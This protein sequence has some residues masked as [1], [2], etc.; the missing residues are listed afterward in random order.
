MLSSRHPH[1]PS[2]SRPPQAGRVLW[3]FLGVLS[4]VVVIGT[5]WF[6]RPPGQGRELKQKPGD[7]QVA[8]R[9]STAQ[10]PA[11]SVPSNS[12][13]EIIAG[14]A[15]TDLSHAPLTLAQAEAWKRNLQQLA[16]LQT[17]A[18]PAIQAFLEKNQ[19]LI[20]D[21][22]ADRQATGNSS[23]RQ[24]LLD[25]LQRNSEPAAQAAALA[26]LQR[27]ADPV[28]IAILSRY[29]DRV[30][31]GKHVESTVLAAREALKLAGSP[32]WD[33][34]DIAPLLDVLKHF[35]GGGAVADLQQASATWFNYAPIV[36][37][38]LPDGAGIPALIQWN[39]NPNAPL[40]AGNDLY[41][42]MLAEACTRSPDALAALVELAQANR[43]PSTAWDGMAAALCGARL[44]LAQTFFEPPLPPAVRS[45]HISAGNQTFVEIP[46]DPVAN[47]TQIAERTKAIEQLLA[48]TDN[49]FGQQ[50]LLKAKQ[51]LSG[52]Q[53]PNK[54]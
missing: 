37:A 2:G 7:N 40:M 42:R 1:R 52:P 9:P 5:V 30:A 53:N 32:D 46:A 27:T 16:A 12:P 29:L 11:A 19:D 34:R 21:N 28:E 33:G 6:F 50:S 4:L 45:F 20:F 36:L 31:P 51:A 43:I 23:L 8:S 25:L 15:R 18:L 35:A 13:N 26:V 3:I 38:G 14:L 10:A 48:A 22:D 41:L 54:P 39:K 44:Q 49:P 17:A 24:A 47:S